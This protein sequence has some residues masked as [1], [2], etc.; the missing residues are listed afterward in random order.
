MS[1]C[2]CSLIEEQAFLLP[3]DKTHHKGHSSIDVL[4]CSS[5]KWEII[6]PKENQFVQ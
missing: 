5:S 2:L 4:S 3:V 1:M 6:L